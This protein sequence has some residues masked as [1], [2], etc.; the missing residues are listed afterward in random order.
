MPVQQLLREIR[1]LGYPGSSNL[2]V[3]YITQG[4]VEADRPHLSPRRAPGSCSPG[5]LHLTG[6]QTAL[7][8]SITTACPEMTALA[9]LVRSFAALLAPD[10]GN[11]RAPAAVD[12]RPP[13]PLTCRTCTPSATASTWTS[14]PPPPPSPCPTTTAGPK[15]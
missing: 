4:R 13:A 10:P 8:A 2:L 14:R 1:E 5:P 15:A 11:D 6:S 9:G 12:H 7:L 3:R